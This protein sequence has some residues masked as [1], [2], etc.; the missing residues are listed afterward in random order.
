MIDK[1]TRDQLREM[2]LAAL[3][4]SG[5]NWQL[6]TSNSFRRISCDGDGDVLAATVH[7]ADGQP[8]L[9]AK[10]EVLQYIVAAQPKMVI[11]LLDEIERLE[12]HLA[13]LVNND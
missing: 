11:D 13:E 10:P 5:P 9:H 8:D 7:H 2:A 12:G 6:W 1:L 3:R 4:K